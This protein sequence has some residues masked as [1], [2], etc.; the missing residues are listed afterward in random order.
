MLSVVLHSSIFVLALPCQ[1]EADPDQ[2]I[3]LSFKEESWMWKGMVALTMSGSEMSYS[4]HSLAS[5]GVYSRIY[6]EFEK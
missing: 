4:L 6:V 2:V 3:L 1:S 5:S